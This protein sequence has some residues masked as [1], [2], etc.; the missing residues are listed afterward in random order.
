VRTG[1]G[2]MVNRSHLLVPK[3]NTTNQA[4]GV[5]ITRVQKRV[6][7]TRRLSQIHQ[8]HAQ[9]TVQETPNVPKPSPTKPR[10]LLYVF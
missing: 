3:N 5:T 10:V 7:K 1:S 8:P 4:T 2:S 6:R 9:I